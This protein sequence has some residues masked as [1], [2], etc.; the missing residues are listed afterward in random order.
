MIF[1]SSRFE[2]SN[3]IILNIISK[4][5]EYIKTGQIKLNKYNIRNK[6]Q[7]QNRK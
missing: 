3:I 5:D 7:N 1:P 4:S 6:S 2:L